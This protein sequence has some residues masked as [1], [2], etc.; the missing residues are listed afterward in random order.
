MIN[1]INSRKSV[2]KYEDEPLPV[3]LLSKIR[4][5]IS[6]AKPLFESIPMETFLIEDGQQ[7]KA[8]FTGLMAK[9]T[10]VEAPHYLAFTSAIQEGHLENIGF[11]GEE[12][13]LKLTE[14]GIG[15]CWL[16]SSIKQEVFKKIVKVQDN[17]NYI[18]LIALGLPV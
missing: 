16:G 11:I 2:R 9:Y 1:A 18:I 5:I 17:Q 10:K 6:E 12:I 7:I 14:L 13:V 4:T 8:T 3:D 15:T